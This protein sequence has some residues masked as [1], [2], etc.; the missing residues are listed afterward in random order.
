M[1]VASA[2]S[3]MP[4][5]Y[6][7]ENAAAEE[8]CMC[9]E[10]AS[11]MPRHYAAENDPEAEAVPEAPRAS[12]M[13]RHYAAENRPLRA[14]LQSSTAASMMPRHY[15]AENRL[16]DRG[17]RDRPARFNDAAALRRGKRR[18]RSVAH[19]DRLRFNDA[20]ALRRGKREAWSAQLARPVASMMPRHY[21]AENRNP[22]LSKIA[23]TLL[24]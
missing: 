8:T 2:A 16:L 17:V 22:V 12:M 13:P 15:A 6:A 7:A 20:A 18:H 9:L 3:M 21:A 4:R 19:G 1:D 23:W 10:S 14:R 5:H 11:M 24:Q